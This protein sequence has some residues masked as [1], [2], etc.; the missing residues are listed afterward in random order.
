MTSSISAKVSEVQR[1]SRAAQSKDVRMED[2]ESMGKDRLLVAMPTP[3]K[4]RQ[5]K[6]GDRARKGMGLFWRRSA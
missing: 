6:D 5:H 3:I 2:R 4:A 1:C